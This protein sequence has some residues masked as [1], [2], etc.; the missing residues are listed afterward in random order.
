[1]AGI[2]WK[3]PNARPIGQIG[4][5]RACQTGQEDATLPPLAAAQLQQ[6]KRWYSRVLT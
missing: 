2:Q 1:M 3:D 5:D 6:L 4:A